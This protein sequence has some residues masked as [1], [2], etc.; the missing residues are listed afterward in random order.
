MN[1]G[2]NIG[3]PLVVCLVF[4]GL[5]APPAAAQ[6]GQGGRRPN[7]VYVFSDDHAV[8]ALGAYGHALSKLAPTPNLDRIAREGAVFESSFC[9]NSIC[10]PSR[11]VVLTGRFSHL[12]GKRDNSDEPF[13]G[14]QTT[15]PKLLQAAGYDT[16]FFGKWHLRSRPTGFDEWAVLPGQGD[17]YNPDFV[18]P[19]GRHREAGYVGDLVTDKAIDYLRRHAEGDEPFLLWVGPKAP[20]RNWMPGPHELDLYRDVEFP[21]PATLFDDY[22]GRASP[23]SRQEMTIA[24]H[25]SDAY[26]LKLTPPLSEVEDEASIDDAFRRMSAE[27]RRAWDDAYAAENARYLARRDDMSDA[28]RTRWKYQRYAGDYLRCVAS[29]DRSVGRLLDELDALGLAEDTIVVYSSDQ[30]FYLGEHGWFDKRWIYEESLRMPL[31]MRWPGEVE[32]GARPRQL[33]QNLDHAPTLL[34]A[35]GVDVPGAMQGQSLLPLVTGGEPGPWRDAIY[36]HYFE[37]PGVHAVR[38]HYGVRTDRYK[39]VRFY[40]DDGLDAWELY[41]L[42]ADPHELHSVADDPAYAEVRRDLTRRLAALREQY[43]DDEGPPVDAR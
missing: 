11:A 12:N 43:A 6:R 5:A 39:L 33:V 13:D 30:G 4:L 41:D 10:A 27:Q 2:F 8:Q 18:T 22:A 20:H 14:S 42:D 23:A 3:V 40:G 16:A 24:A 9:T 19:E 37:F 38:R 26:D 31:L 32:A 1:R 28:E 34:E 29:V 21:E 35:A 7:I 17:Y 36:Y 25:L 15:F